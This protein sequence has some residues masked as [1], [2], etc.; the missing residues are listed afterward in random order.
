MAQ[1][2]Q[3]GPI[4]S[5]V[6]AR[7]QLV[8]GASP[9]VAG[10]GAPDSQGNY[11]G[12]DPDICR[13]ITAAIFGDASRIRF[14]PLTSQA[15]I[16]ALQSGEV[17]VVV[18]TFTWTMS[19]EAGAGLQFGPT[20]FFDGQGFLVRRSANI[21]RAADLNGATVCTVSGSTNELNLHQYCNLFEQAARQTG[22]DNFGLAQRKGM[23]AL[24]PKSGLPFKLLESIPYDPKAQ[25]LS[26][27]VTKIRGLNPDLLLVVTR[28]ADAIKLVRD[29]VRQKF[30]PMGII[31]PGAPGLYDEEFYKAL[32]PLADYHIDALPWAN[33]KSKVTQALEAAYTKAQPKFRFAVECF[34]VGFT[35]DALMVAGDAFKRA[36]TTNGPELMKALKA[37]NLV[38][39]TM[40][41][42]PIKFDEKGQNNDIPSASVQNRNQTPTV[43]LPAEVATMTPVLPMPPWQGRK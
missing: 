8:C 39:H 43:V 38:E 34:N 7:N 10:F 9:G 26:V 24:F 15:R 12:F 36:G 30:Q 2:V 33:P 14:V 11:R 23:D 42:G 18:R 4:L 19:R 13:A 27:E 35:F 17:D 3:A 31:S 6:R 37:T 20:V 32:G 28:A 5:A 16:P 1:N 25:D 29:T 22:N 21:Q 41:G 40:I